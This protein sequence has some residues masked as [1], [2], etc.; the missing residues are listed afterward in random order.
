RSVRRTGARLIRYWPSPPRCKRRVTEISLKSSSP[1]APSSLSNRSSTSQ[2]SAGAW[3]GEPAKRTSSGF[4]ARS[5]LGLCEPE[6]QRSASATFDLPEPLGPTTT[7]TPLSSRT[8]T[9]SGNDLKPRSLIER[10]CT[11]AG[12]YGA[13]RMPPRPACLLVLDHPRKRL[14]RELVGHVRMDLLD[15]LLCVVEHLVLGLA[16]DRRAAGAVDHLGHRP[17]SRTTPPMLPRYAATPR[18]SSASRAASCSAAFFERPRP[19]PTSS[20]SITAA[21]V[22]RRSCGGP[23]TSSTL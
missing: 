15:V 3:P 2:W 4:S 20:P 17:S 18:R 16:A 14:A 12:G 8:S 13:Q 22:K 6:A 7:A 5:S 11:R 9:G 23:C 1:K 21:Q 19:T 10:R